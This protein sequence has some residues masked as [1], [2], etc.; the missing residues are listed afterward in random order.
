MTERDFD[1]QIAGR[2]AFGVQ[3]CLLLS[4]GYP[5]PSPD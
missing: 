4:P 5:L 2:P 1:D 3:R